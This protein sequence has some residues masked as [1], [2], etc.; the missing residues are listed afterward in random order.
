MRHAE[1]IRVIGQLL[2][3]ASIRSFELATKGAN[4][5]VTSDSL[6]QSSAWGFYHPPSQNLSSQSTRRP[7]MPGTV[8]FSLANIFRLEIHAQL[9]RRLNSFHTETY[10]T[11]SQLLRT[12]GNLLERMNVWVFQTRWEYESVAVDFI[13]LDG[14]YDSL[15]NALE[16]LQRWS[17]S[18]R[19]RRSSLKFPNSF[20]PQ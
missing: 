15:T 18:S 5:I 17:A 14:Q 6:P 10:P 9:R 8:R 19:L 16:I 11:L 7:V 1:S 13:R 20:R 3:D 12:L 4:Y 2:E